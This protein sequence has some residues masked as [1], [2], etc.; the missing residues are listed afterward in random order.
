MKKILLTALVLIATSLVSYAQY[1]KA[2][3]DAKKITDAYEQSVNN[4][5]SCEE[6]D[7]ASIN[8]FIQ[9]MGLVEVEYDESEEMTEKENELLEEQIDRITNKVESM[10]QQFDCPIEEEEEEVELIPTT[11]QEWDELINS[12][13]AVT[14]KFEAVKSVD[15]DNDDDLNKL[16]ELLTEAEPIVTRI[17]NADTENITKKQSERLDAINDRFVKA[18]YRLGFAEEDEE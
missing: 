16:M 11:T 2:Y 14:K 9:L 10:K 18:A 6:L 17:D 15:Y 3:N 8:F 4:A 5:K 13:E 12:Y 7:D 1:S